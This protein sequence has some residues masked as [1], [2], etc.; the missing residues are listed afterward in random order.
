MLVGHLPTSS[1][2][3]HRHRR[4]SRSSSR[5]QTPTPTTTGDG[6]G[7]GGIAVLRGVLQACNLARREMVHF[8]ANLSS[9]MMFEV[10]VRLF[11]GFRAKKERDGGRPFCQLLSNPTNHL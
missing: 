6:D 7:D 5:A 10:R 1:S 3:S 4:S 9:F 2:A 8:V 11:G